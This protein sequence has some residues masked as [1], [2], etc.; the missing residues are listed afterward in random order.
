MAYKQDG[1]RCSQRL[2]DNGES[3]KVDL[4]GPVGQC[5]SDTL[6]VNALN[7]CRCMVW[8]VQYSTCMCA[9]AS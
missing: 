9:H 5:E 1:M 3:G 2:R 7:V 6:K 8:G 4:G